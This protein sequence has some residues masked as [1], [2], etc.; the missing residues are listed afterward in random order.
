MANSLLGAQ[1][2]YKIQVKQGTG[3]ED[4]DFEKP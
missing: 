4:G 2:G 3:K 1:I